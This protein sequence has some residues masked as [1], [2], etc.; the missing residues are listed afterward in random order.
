MTT[1]YARAGGGNWGTSTTW[2]LSSGGGADGSVP[3][4]ADDVKL[5]AASGAVTINGTS[6]SPSLCRSFDCTGY[7]NTL[8]HANSTALAVGDGTAGVFKLVAGM[9]YT[10]GATSI[11]R[12]VS[13]TTGNNITFGGKTLG[14][15]TFN[16]TGGGWT[17]QDTF[18]FQGG[19]VASSMVLTAGSVDTNSQTGSGQLNASGT[20]TRSLTLGTTNWTV[21]G[22]IGWDI[23]DSTNMTLSAASSTITFSATTGSTPFAG[24]GLTYGTFT[25][26]ALTTGTTTIT[27]SN[28][29]GTLTMSCGA[30]TTSS[31]LLGGNQTVTGTFT[32]N[33][34]ST[35]NR[36]YIRSTVRGTARTIT[37]AT[38]VAS[39]LDLQDITGAGTG[40]WNLSA[41]TGL[42]GDCG[43]NSGI[44]FTTPANQYWVPSAGTST[45]NFNAITRWASASGGTAGTGR[46]PLPQDTCIIDANSID[47][48]SRALTQGMVRIGAINFT[49]ATNTPTFT[50]STVC[51][52]FGSIT[53]ISGMT[54]TGSSPGYTYE[55]RGSSTIACATK[56]WAKQFTID[57][58]GGTLTQ[59][60]N[61]ISTAGLLFTGGTFNSSTYTTACSTIQCTNGTATFGAGG[62][63]AS[64]SFTQ[65]G[66]AGVCTINGTSTFGG[67]FTLNMGAGCTGHLYVNANMTFTGSPS[68]QEGNMTI[69]DATISGSSFSYSGAGAGGGSSAFMVG[70]VGG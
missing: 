59:A 54:L 30:G 17:F 28:T 55:G 14:P 32:A 44:T 50:T 39:Y 16:G 3:T 23:T 11:L 61:F 60:D 7:T 24:G 13:T 48:G 25:G 31:Y 37:A 26:T 68:V 70:H 64:S 67:G 56:S 41:I 20:T 52:F 8:S 5:D 18:A 49:G 36:N 2:S 65:N 40:S 4:A 1:Y 34:N 45:G 58:A 57:C 38:V 33:G 35:T 22:T 19:S 69:T 9:T 6:G 21:S 42:S 27:G 53:L 47:A 66:S 29:F 51:S 63:T 10:P 46:I 15:T 43:N 12:F 62:I